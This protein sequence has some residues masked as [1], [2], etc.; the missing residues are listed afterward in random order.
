VEVAAQDDSAAQS[1]ASSLSADKINSQLAKAG[2]PPA[3][4][5][6]A[7]AVQVGP[8]AP[9]P[10]AAGADSDEKPAPDE[11]PAATPTQE[12]GLNLF[13]IIGASAGGLCVWVSAVAGVTYVVRRRQ[14]ERRP[15]FDPNEGAIDAKLVFAQP[16]VN[17]GTSNGTH[18]TEGV[19]SPALARNG[20]K[21]TDRSIGNEAGCERGQDDYFPIF[22]PEGKN[23]PRQVMLESASTRPLRDL[24]HSDQDGQREQQSEHEKE[25]QDRKKQAPSGRPDDLE[26]APSPPASGMAVNDALQRPQNPNTPILNLMMRLHH[27]ASSRLPTVGSIMGSSL[28]RVQVDSQLVPMR[29]PQSLHDGEEAPLNLMPR[30]SRMSPQVT[31]DVVMHSPRSSRLQFFHQPRSLHTGEGAAQQLHSA[32]DS[33]QQQPDSL[34]ASTHMISSSP[35]TA[36]SGSV[37][38]RALGSYARGNGWDGNSKLAQSSPRGQAP[39]T[40]FGPDTHQSPGQAS[41]MFLGPDDASVQGTETG[42][43]ESEAKVGQIVCI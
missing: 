10:D 9:A 41:S 18:A 8:P 7:A 25:R 19:K 36:S 15:K 43:P 4:V 21:S 31:G 5:L 28:R 13:V 16:G 32:A 6:E 35:P 22:V 1:T 39:A 24:D 12:Q 27:A 42:L 40:L 14:Q 20:S 34:T 29:Q 2:L 3:Q 17:G 33:Q 11:A 38:S 26:A 23:V 37:T 30:L